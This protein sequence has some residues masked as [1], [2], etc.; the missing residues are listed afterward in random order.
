MSES[1]RKETGGAI[2]ALLS[3]SWDRFR[4]TLGWSGRG[5][6][7]FKRPTHGKQS[8][9]SFLFPILGLLFLFQGFFMTHRMIETYAD[10]AIAMGDGEVIAVNE[11]LYRRI[12]AN[13]DLWGAMTVGGMK[14]DFGNLVDLGKWERENLGLPP[15]TFE[16]V[17]AQIEIKGTAGF[18]PLKAFSRG[19]VSLSDLRGVER[20]RFSRLLGM[21]FLGLLMALLFMPMAVRQKN[22]AATSD[23]QEW[24]FSLP[25]REANLLAGTFASSVLI[26]PLI[27]IIL[28]PFLTNLLLANGHGVLLAA[29]GAMGLTFLISIAISGVEILLDTWMRARAPTIVLKNAQMVFSVLGLLSF[30]AVLAAC[31]AGG[32]S[33]P[34]INWLAQRLPGSLGQPL[35]EV[36]ISPLARMAGWSAMVAVVLGFGGCLLAGRFMRSGWLSGNGMQS[37]NRGSGGTSLKRGSLLKFEGL[38][39]LRDRTLATQVILVPVLLVGYQVL[40]NPSM[41]QS[42]TAAG[43]CTMAYTCGTY[44][45]LITA[46]QLLMSEAKGVWL[47]YNLPVPI[48]AYFKRRETLWRSVATGL[49]LVL[50]IVMLATSGAFRAGD[51]WRYLAA[52]LGV[53]VVGRVVSGIVLGRPQMPDV[54]S[55]EMP[56]ISFG[57]MY[58]A[59]AMAG[60]YGGLLWKGLAWPLFSALVI[61]WFLGVAV[62][63]RRDVS[64]SYLMEPV[65]EEP[66]SW[67]VDDGLWAVVV[68]FVVQVVVTMIGVV[69]GGISSGLILVSFVAGGVVALL[70]VKLRQ[71]SKRIP[72]P[73]LPESDHG[74]SLKTTAR[75]TVVAI[76]LCL[77]VGVGWTKVLETGLFGSEMH[78]DDFA[79]SPVVLIL[80]AV[81]AAPILEELLFRGFMCRT[82]LAFWTKKNAVLGSALIFAMVHPGTSFP[83]VFLL[84]LATAILYLRSRS[85]I[86]GMILHALY[87]LGIVG[88]ASMGLTVAFNGTGT[89]VVSRTFSPGRGGV[90]GEDSRRGSG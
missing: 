84:G 71:N 52:L 47:I 16:E 41:V 58:G 59:M 22:L 4:H 11:A 30:Y 67:G 85:V 82:M 25:I 12:L 19:G 20:K 56:K 72:L 27:Y 79:W 21:I 75:E 45:S 42:I 73:E 66:P 83:P 26:R 63:Q 7:R 77:A 68:F 89:R 2:K 17:A 33:F 10:R 64:F 1:T 14:E 13:Q 80:L 40:I 53:W 69:A 9:H 23:H 87:N 88:L 43:I 74:R 5:D 34:W 86:P 32:P 49:A 36:M 81:V 18:R 38:L 15:L 54:A 28:W 31:L 51:L 65:E 76:L 62:W 6:R 57:R 24:L 61:F 29:G 37:G 44:A 48:A 78:P 55:G 90:C 70:F 8:K 35:G 60:I 46:P 50:V 3:L 39:L